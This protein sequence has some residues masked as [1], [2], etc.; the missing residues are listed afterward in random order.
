ME[1]ILAS[2]F[3]PTPSQLNCNYSHL[4]SRGLN[5]GPNNQRLLTGARSSALGGS[6]GAQR[7][8]K[9]PAELNSANHILDSVHLCYAPA[10]APAPCCCPVWLEPLL[11]RA[12]VRACVRACWFVLQHFPPFPLPTYEEAVDTSVLR[13]SCES[14]QLSATPM[15]FVRVSETLCNT[16]F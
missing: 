11:H 15:C 3:S 2:F 4:V 6:G 13:R 16:I 5:K 14:S 7:R 8:S 1:N 12:C 9:P 10:P